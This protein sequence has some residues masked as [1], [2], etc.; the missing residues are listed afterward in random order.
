MKRLLVAVGILLAVGGL[1]AY[2][3]L[4][5]YSDRKLQTNDYFV[6]NTWS[7][8]WNVSKG[9]NLSLSFRP[10]ADWSIESGMEEPLTLPPYN[11]TFKWV[12]TF[13]IN[14]TNPVGNTSTIH[15]Y[16]I[17]TELGGGAGKILV[18]P[19]YMGLDN[20]GVVITENEYPK[21][22]LIGQDNVVALGKMQ[23]D[24]NYVVNCTL[25]PLVIL[26][27]YAVNGSLWIH[28]VGPCL[29]LRLY[30]Q[31]EDVRYLYRSP[32]LL[33]ASGS[34][35][36]VGGVAAILGMLR[37]RSKHYLNNKK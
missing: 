36:A 24:G 21:F 7:I 20:Q 14:I 25:D 12:K 1:V 16:M 33:P 28:D 2:P 30:R 17:I 4:F 6:D 15:V 9:E 11:Q 22:A 27:R 31:K 8:A 23:Y 37:K 10:S 29:E 13:Q 5:S 19:D 3:L 26:D 35:V 34:L 18:Y 32:L